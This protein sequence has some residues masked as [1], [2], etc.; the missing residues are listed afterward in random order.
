MN[1][2]AS[3]APVVGFKD[4][5]TGLMVF[6]IL[7]IIMGCML[8]LMVPFMVFGQLMGWACSRCRTDADAFIASRPLH[9]SGHAV[10]LIWLGI[11]SIQC[12]RWRARCC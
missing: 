6:G 4:R 3:V 12:R 9:V 5:R 8:A 2:N 1:E 7:I 10:A 11:G